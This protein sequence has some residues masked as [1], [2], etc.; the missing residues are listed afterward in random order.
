MVARAAALLAIAALAVVLED[1]LSSHF[2]AD[3]AARTS[4]RIGLAHRRSP[5]ECCSEPE[6]NRPLSA[7]RKVEAAAG[8]QEGFML[9]STAGQPW[10]DAL[11]HPAAGFELVMGDGQPD[12]VVIF[13]DVE[14]TRLWLCRI[15]GLR[16]DS[17]S[18]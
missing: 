7:W 2:V 3:R 5:A 11:R 9:D 1:G 13:I 8:F 4:A 17:P 12:H 10:L 16:S 6:G 18:S 15:G 14:V